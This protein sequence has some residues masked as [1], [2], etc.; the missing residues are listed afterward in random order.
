MESYPESGRNDKT[1]MYRLRSEESPQPRRQKKKGKRGRVNLGPRGKRASSTGKAGYSIHEPARDSVLGDVEP[2]SEPEVYHEAP[3]D[4]AA[5]CSTN[6]IKLDANQSYKFV[7]VLLL[8]FEYH[9]LL[10]LPS[11]IAGVKA[12]FQR[13]GYNVTPYSIPMD[14]SLAR[15]KDKLKEFFE[16]QTENGPELRIVYYTGHGGADRNKRLWLS[17]HNGPSPMLEYCST[18][19]SGWNVYPRQ[20]KVRWDDI[21]RKMYEAE[22]DTLAI[23]DCCDAGLAA[24][25][26]TGNK[27]SNNHRTEIIGACGWNT[28]TYHHMSP[29]MWTVLKSGLFYKQDSTPTSALVRKMN[30]KLVSIGKHAPQA[31][32]YCLTPNNIGRI[33]LPRLDTCIPADEMIIYDKYKRSNKSNLRLKGQTALILGGES[34]IGRSAAITFALEGANVTILYLAEREQDILALNKEVQRLGAGPIRSYPLAD[35]NNTAIL[36]SSAAKLTGGFRIDILVNNLG[37]QIENDRTAS[38]TGPFAGTSLR[39]VK[40]EGIIINTMSLENSTGTIPPEGSDVS[41]GV[42][43]Y[44]TRYQSTSEK[45]TVVAILPGLDWP[46]LV[47]AERAGQVLDAFVSAASATKSLKTRWR[48]KYCNLMIKLL[49]KWP[50][51]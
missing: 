5:V 23:L 35:G 51:Y 6:T 26:N 9:D 17:S 24:T 22:C 40:T 8:S 31:V 18:P 16:L 27:T 32:H 33:V 36:R 12:A 50:K 28:S 42:I 1:A 47:N 38:L 7:S 49:Y 14:N 3:R 13:L 2:E 20:S 15:L 45:Q 48:G 39:R 43:E 29:A 4:P 37:Y 11:E 19:W 30:N 34:G 46:L 10:T 44:L 41:M 21:A 25:C